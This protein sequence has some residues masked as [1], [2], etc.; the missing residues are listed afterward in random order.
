M[1]YMKRKDYEQ[2]PQE[3]KILMRS[4]RK[5]IPMGVVVAYKIAYL[6]TKDKS[7]L[8]YLSKIDKNNTMSYEDYY[9]GD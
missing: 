1:M 4:K 5:Y 2:M 7:H 9:V 3:F 6:I 8:K